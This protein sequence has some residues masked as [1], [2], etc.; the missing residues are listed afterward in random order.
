[1]NSN[2]K[3]QDLVHPHMYPLVYRHSGVFEEEIVGVEDVI[4]NWSGKGAVI[5]GKDPWDRFRYKVSGS[6]PPDFW[7]VK[8][9]WLLTN[10]AFYDG[11]TA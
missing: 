5:Q 1:P 8:Y 9:S 3:V 4:T 10:I 11:S 2:N 6:A 7:S